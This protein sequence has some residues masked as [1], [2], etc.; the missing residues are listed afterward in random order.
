M[1]SKLSPTTIIILEVSA[2]FVRF[3]YGDVS[4]SIYMTGI[5][6]ADGNRDLLNGC[7]GVK[8]LP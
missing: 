3:E 6:D 1:R 5:R 4:R 2:A 7:K 8:P